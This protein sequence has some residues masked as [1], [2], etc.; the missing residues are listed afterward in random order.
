MCTDLD[1]ETLD[2]RRIVTVNENI[3]TVLG[4]SA[5]SHLV[6]INSMLIAKSTGDRLLGFGVVSSEL[7]IFSRK[8]DTAMAALGSLTFD[9]VKKVSQHKKLSRERQHLLRTMAKSQRAKTL[10][11]P[12]LD[13]KEETLK[14]LASLFEEDRQKLGRQLGR[15]IQLCKTGNAL[16]R[17]AKIEAAYGGAIHRVLLQIAEQIEGTV[18]QILITLNILKTAIDY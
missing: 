18:Q 2:L 9:L 12:T 11:E 17:C 14:Q 15:A 1:L 5:S 6:A 3:K 4:I 13:R 8:L 16:A 7:R 10:L